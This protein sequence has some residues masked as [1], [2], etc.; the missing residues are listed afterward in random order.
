MHSLTQSFVTLILV[1]C[2]TVF[3]SMASAQNSKSLPLFEFSSLRYN[4][5][6]LRAGPGVRYP[7]EWVFH[8]KALPVRIIR[9]YATWRL[10][11][12]WEGDQGWVGL[13]VN[14]RTPGVHAHAMRHPKGIVGCPVYITFSVCASACACI[15]STCPGAR[16]PCAAARRSISGPR[17]SSAGTSSSW[18]GR[19]ARAK[20]NR[21]TSRLRVGAGGGRCVVRSDLGIF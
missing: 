9:K 1:L 10:I 13:L 12:D 14:S 17:C 2:Q 8:R 15:R 7:I 4:E 11:R 18:R 3:L 20:C 5:V 21:T 16:G 6:N 19:C